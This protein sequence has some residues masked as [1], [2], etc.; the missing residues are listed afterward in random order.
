MTAATEKGITPSSKWTHLPLNILHTVVALLARDGVASVAEVW[1]EA[2][3]DESLKLF[4]SGGMPICAV[5]WQRVIASS[6]P[7]FFPHHGEQTCTI[8]RLEESE[9][10]GSL[11]TCLIQID[12]V[13]LVV[14]HIMDK[15]YKR[16]VKNTCYLCMNMDATQ[17]YLDSQEWHSVTAEYAEDLVAELTDLYNESQDADFESG[18]DNYMYRYWIDDLLPL[19]CQRCGKLD[20][21][22][23]SSCAWYYGEG[24]VLQQLQ[25]E[26]LER[27]KL[28]V[29]Q[30]GPCD[31]KHKGGSSAK[32]LGCACLHCN[33]TPATGCNFCGK[34]C[35]ST[36]CFHT[37]PP[38]PAKLHHSFVIDILDSEDPQ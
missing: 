25:Q 30:K 24:V 23:S 19:T 36:L 8:V 2:V 22:L 21:D 37:N 10:C 17:Q 7:A 28:Q 13:T 20:C 5:C 16:P 4:V 31:C 9:D 38:K 33:N 12:L 3:Q 11:S 32:P 27:H 34:C 15:G 26:L 35:R 18:Y 1:P 6:L 29:N 14:R